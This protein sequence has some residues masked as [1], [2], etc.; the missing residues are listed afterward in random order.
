M[1]LRRGGRLSKKKKHKKLE[2]PIKGELD[3]LENAFD[4][5][6]CHD[7]KIEL[8]KWH[9]EHCE[10]PH[11]YPKGTTLHQKG[12]ESF[13]KSNQNK[14]LK[15]AQK[16]KKEGSPLGQRKREK[17]ERMKE[18]IKNTKK[19]EWKEGKEAKKKGKKEMNKRGKKGRKKE[20]KNKK[21]MKK[22]GKAKRNKGKKKQTK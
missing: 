3:K 20:R 17:N 1:P 18:E 21:E 8:H 4:V 16:L 12:H 9:M 19:R 10:Q 6:P 2:N 22:E 7:G 14:N 11:P 5:K 15:E 13:K